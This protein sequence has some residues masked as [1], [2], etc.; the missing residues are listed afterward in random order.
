MILACW[1]LFAT[2]LAA[3]YWIQYNDLRTRI[4]S[5]N[6][7]L[8]GIDLG[9]D[10]GNGSRSWQNDTRALAGQT[11]F[12]VT[13]QVVNI[14]YDVGIYGTEV[15]SINGVKKTGGFGWTYWALNSTD[16]SWSIVM[17]NVD[18]HLVTNN[19][20]YMWYYSNSF[21]PPP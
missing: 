5:S 20:I 11:L 18:R 8:T 21:N 19:E 15:L 17:E 1:V 4:G 13:K 16:R 9:I 10:Y 3:Y 7:V 6:S 12:D 14:T 2:F